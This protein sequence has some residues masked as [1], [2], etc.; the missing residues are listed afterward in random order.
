MPNE[1][2]LSLPNCWISI[3]DFEKLAGNSNYFDQ[4]EQDR[5][6]VIGFG[7]GTSLLLHAGV[8][9][10][11]FVNQLANHLQKSGCGAVRLEFS[12]SEG[13]F[14]FLDRNGFL[15]LLTSTVTTSPD[16]PDSSGADI[17]RG[18][19]A[20]MVEIAE[21][22]PG[23]IGEA[24]LNIVRRLVDTLGDQYDAD[25]RLRVKNAVYSV[26]S[27]LVNNVYDHSGSS[28]SGYAALQAYR[29]SGKVQIVVSDSGIGIAK[30]LRNARIASADTRSDSQ[31]VLG[32]IDGRL[33][34]YGQNA[35]H[36]CGLQLC[37]DL[38]REF[39]RQ[40]HLRTPTVQV[41]LA[42][43]P[44]KNSL[45]RWV[46]VPEAAFAG[47]HVCIEFSLDPSSWTAL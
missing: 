18:H 6:I 2:R 5:T 42:P 10:L 23:V 15:K 47:T 39:G 27:E 29:R 41:L 25:L 24:R 38:V 31:L 35:G 7:S 46:T 8:C 12:S 1:L 32:A 33:S 34:R 26:L 36:G 45:Q 13:L 40:F 9:L 4:I 14:S 37:A 20:T 43:D 19:A 21:I 11:S 44:S 3:R 30:S 22:Q 17:Y 28:I 16:R